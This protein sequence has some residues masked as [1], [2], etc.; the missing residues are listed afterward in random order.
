MKW[1]YDA[2]DDRIL[3]NHNNNR[4]AAN[5]L[6]LSLSGKLIQSTSEERM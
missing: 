3:Q 6:K 2:I 4:D 1:I 5:K